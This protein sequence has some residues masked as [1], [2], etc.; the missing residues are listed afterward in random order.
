MG[1]VIF[2]ST[3]T[4][5]SSHKYKSVPLE[6]RLCTLCNLNQIENEIHILFIAINTTW[7][8]KIG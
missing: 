5:H 4:W 8:E 2:S 6:R 1:K 3:E 7:K